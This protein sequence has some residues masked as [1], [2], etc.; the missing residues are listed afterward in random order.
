MDNNCGQL[1]TIVH[2]CGQLS[3]VETTV[4]NCGYQLKTI[5]Q[6]KGFYKSCLGAEVESWSSYVWCFFDTYRARK[7]KRS[8]KQIR[9]IFFNTYRAR[10]MVRMCFLIRFVFRAPNVPKKNDTYEFQESKNRPKDDF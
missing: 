2:N 7:T 8:K 6:F 10:K 1:C 9:I 5:D 4:N 3:K